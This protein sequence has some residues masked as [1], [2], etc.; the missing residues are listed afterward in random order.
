MD[1]IIDM[2]VTWWQFTV[3][4]ILIIIGFIANRMGVD[5]EE[6]IIHFKYDEMPVLKPLRIETAGKGFWGAIWM[7]LTGVRHWEVAE[8][9]HFKIG[10]KETEYFIPA[11]FVFD[12]ASIPK[13]LHTWLSPTG[14]LLM[15]GL[16]HDYAYK[17]ETLL[18]KYGKETMGVLTQKRADEIFRDI[19]IE[20][21]G[22][23]LLN[24]LA[25]W[26]LRI[27]GFMAW[28]GHRKRNCKISGLN[29]FNASK[30]LEEEK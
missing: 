20:Q 10:D 26:A 30:L 19:N 15:G 4:G 18:Q 22:F 11:G 9:W 1:F 3:V 5:C 13:F 23:H 2:M 21:N 8:D 7:W 24:N 14:V 17:Y 29:E 12:G 25:Y 27:G 6:D 16:V 28:N